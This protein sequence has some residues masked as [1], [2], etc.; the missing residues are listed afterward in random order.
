[1]KRSLLSLCTLA[2]ALVG[3]GSAMATPITKSG[4]TVVS[5]GLTFS[6]FTCSFTGSGV[7]TGACDQI[8]VTALTPQPAGIQ[9]STD[10]AVIGGPS[11]ADAA[12]AFHVNSTSGINMVGLS[13]TRHSKAWT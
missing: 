9:F 3:A 5:G 13:F 7:H 10:M 11:G 4:L 6:N 12:L 1:M 2:V 8:Q